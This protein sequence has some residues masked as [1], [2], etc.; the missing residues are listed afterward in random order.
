M[1]RTAAGAA[2]ARAGEGLA[3]ATE[4]DLDAAVRVALEAIGMDLEAERQQLA[5]RGERQRH[6]PHL[7][8]QL[9][10]RL[11]SR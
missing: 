8:P 7:W 4:A 1:A 3:Q 5:E 2:E 11:F 10:P 9:W 6:E